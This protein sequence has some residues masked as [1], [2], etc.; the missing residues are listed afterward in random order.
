M[1]GMRK[2]HQELLQT[3]HVTLAKQLVGEEL[4][5]HLLEENIITEEMLQVIE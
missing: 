4:L 1:H 3:N 2:E 5:Q